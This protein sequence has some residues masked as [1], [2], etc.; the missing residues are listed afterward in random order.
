MGKIVYIALNFYYNISKGVRLICATKVD[1]NM[2]V[3]E[4]GISFL[5]NSFTHKRFLLHYHLWR[6]IVYNVGVTILQIQL[7]SYALLKWIFG[8]R[9]DY[10]H[11]Y[12]KCFLRCGMYFKTY[13]LNSFS[14]FHVVCIHSRLYAVPHESIRTHYK[15]GDQLLKK[16]FYR[17]IWSVFK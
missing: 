7:D 11:N 2:L 8:C 5:Y 14:A 12:W 13:I 9:T 16:N 15:Y 17:V 4:Y 6:E 1:C 3:R 10:D